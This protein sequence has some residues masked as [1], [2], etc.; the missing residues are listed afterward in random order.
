MQTAGWCMVV[1]AEVRTDSEEAALLMDAMD[2]VVK[3]VA[4]QQQPNMLASPPRKE[5]EEEGPCAW[6][7]NTAV[8]VLMEVSGI[9]I[10]SLFISEKE[11]TN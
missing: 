7:T 3:Q 10:M 9:Y 5:A 2:M 4:G 6:A 1:R 8:G 11:K